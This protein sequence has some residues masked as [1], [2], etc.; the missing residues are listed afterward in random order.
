MS[1]EKAY[2]RGSYNVKNRRNKRVEIAI[3]EQ[4]RSMIDEKAKIKGMSRTDFIVW[5]CENKKVKGYNKKS[6]PEN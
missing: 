2:T 4:E 5:C 3:S 1:K 6:L